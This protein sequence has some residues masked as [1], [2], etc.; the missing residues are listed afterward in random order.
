MNHLQIVA[1][2]CVYIVGF[3]ATAGAAG[4]DIASNCR[5][6]ND[7]HTGGVTGVFLPTV[8]AGYVVLLIVACVASPPF[9]P[10]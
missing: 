3:F 9:R 5:N 2:L 1:I 4:T 6:D 10:R 7:V 8:L